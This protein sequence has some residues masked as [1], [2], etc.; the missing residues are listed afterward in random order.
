MDATSL[1]TW[2]K[3]LWEES[4][5]IVRVSQGYFYDEG[6]FVKVVG[7]EKEVLIRK[8]KIISVQQ[9]SKLEASENGERK[10]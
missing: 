5:D 7:D 10:F 1:H 3:V 2:K 6:D 9:A 4:P 8:D